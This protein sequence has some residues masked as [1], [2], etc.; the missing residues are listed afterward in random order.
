M[1]ASSASKFAVRG[2]TK[3]A[4]RELGRSG[5]PCQRRLSGGRNPDVAMEALRRLR[6]TGAR[7]PS[8]LGDSGRHRIPLEPL[9]SPE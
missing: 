9:R 4:A 6:S 1:A 8:G 3:T 7:P 5:I 2:L